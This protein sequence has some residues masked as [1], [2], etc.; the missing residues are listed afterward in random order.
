MGRKLEETVR[1]SDKIMIK[2]APKE[3]KKEMSEEILV[4]KPGKLEKN[5][6]EDDKPTSEKE[7]EVAKI[8]KDAEIDIKESAKK[9]IEGLIRI[10][11]SQAA[12]DNSKKEEE[13]LALKKEKESIIGELNNILDLLSHAPAPQSKRK[14]DHKKASKKPETSLIR[15]QEN[16]LGLSGIS[17]EDVS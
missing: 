7:E 2:E 4:T 10:V 12:Q 13:R 5:A 9:N 17:K 3:P 14:N 1:A 11:V 15:I 8:S 6:T 16:L